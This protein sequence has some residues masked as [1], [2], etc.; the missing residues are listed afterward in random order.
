MNLDNIQPHKLR[1]M[2]SNG[3]LTDPTSGMSKGYVQAN[4]VILP[5]SC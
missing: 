4:V 3:E 2:I 1:E 5:S